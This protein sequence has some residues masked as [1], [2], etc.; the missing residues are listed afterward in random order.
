MNIEIKASPESGLLTGKIVH[1]ALPV[2]WTLV[3]QESRGPAMACTYDIH[4]HGA[5]LLSARPVNVGDLVMVERGRHKAI[6]Q[7]VWAGDQ[8]SPLRGQFRC[9]AWKAE[10][11]GMKSCGRWK[12][13]TSQW[14]SMACTAARRVALALRRPTGGGGRGFMWTGR[15]R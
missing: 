3:G 9:S 5:R 13:S 10:R 6:C 4:P 2:R 11:R 8:D 14:F 12:S 1:L 15:R 7:V